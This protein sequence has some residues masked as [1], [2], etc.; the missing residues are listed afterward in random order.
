MKMAT[1]PFHGSIRLLFL[2]GL[3]SSKNNESHLIPPK[4]LLSVLSGASPVMEGE[5]FTLHDPVNL[6]FMVTIDPLH[7]DTLYLTNTE[8]VSVGTRKRKFTKSVGKL[9]VG[10][11][12]VC[13]KD[14]DV[15]NALTRLAKLPETVRA[16]ECP[17][18]AFEESKWALDLAPTDWTETNIVQLAKKNKFKVRIVEPNGKYCLGY[19]RNPALDEFPIKKVPCKSGEYEMIFIIQRTTN[20]D[21]IKRLQAAFRAKMEALRN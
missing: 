6:D 2:L 9:L 10:D 7:E 1:S 11:G 4:D 8:E 20:E 19:K 5:S 12:H 21:S 13:T 16:R 18:S 15:E 17:T 14:L 3:S